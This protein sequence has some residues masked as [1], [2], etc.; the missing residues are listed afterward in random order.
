MSFNGNLEEALPIYQDFL[1]CE[2]VKKCLDLEGTYQSRLIGIEN[3]RM[4]VTILRTQG[5]N[6]IELLEYTSHFGKKR[7]IDGW[8][9][10]FCVDS[11]G[12]KCL[13]N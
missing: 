1:G 13:Y 12:I 6:R 3:V 8:R 9:F 4:H 11:D 10:P 7:A 2:L 5:N